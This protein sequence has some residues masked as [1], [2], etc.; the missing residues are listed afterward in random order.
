[1]TGLNA[2]SDG[3]SMETPLLSP[4]ASEDSGLRSFLDSAKL[5]FQASLQLLAERAAFI[6][7]A[8][9]AAI[10]L[11]ESE[12]FVYYAVAGDSAAQPGSEAGIN[13]PSLR[14]CIEQRIPV[15]TA[16]KGKANPF[17]L[18]VPILSAD[19]TIGVLELTGPH[20]YQD[21]D[22]DSV[23]RISNLVGVAVEYHDA[24]ERASTRI[25][26]RDTQ[27]KSEA[28]AT[29]WHA[30]DSVAAQAIQDD[31]SKA[32]ASPSPLN[33]QA[34]ASCGFP[35]SS[36]RRLCVDCERQPD[37]RL[38]S[39]NELFTIPTEENWLAAHGYTILSVLIPTIAAAVYFWLR[40]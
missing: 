28:Q 14:A 8:T 31:Q 13:E 22:I 33:R 35:V 26:A 4:A 39:T 37:L 21:Q 27:I 30:P 3:E 6:A 36:G 20:E 32:A 24:A 7:A 40:R 2:A 15:R 1:L 18:N 10:A 29:S 38:P 34:C 11:K 19:E 12:S 17:G 9:G 16:Q 23:S 25:A 5:E